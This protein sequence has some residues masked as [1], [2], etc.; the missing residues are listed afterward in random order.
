MV[1]IVFTG[2]IVM[3]RILIA[4]AVSAISMSAFADWQNGYTRKDGTY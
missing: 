1:T 4:V 2:E 3:N